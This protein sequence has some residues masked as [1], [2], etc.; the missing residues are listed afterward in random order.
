MNKFLKIFGVALIVLGSV[1]SCF[2]SIAVASYAGVAVA[3][4]G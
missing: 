3:A 4:L 2:T 1:V